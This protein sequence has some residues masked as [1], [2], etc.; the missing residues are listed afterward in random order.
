MWS[1]C[2]GS[3]VVLHSRQKGPPGQ[4]ADALDPG[5]EVVKLCHAEVD[6]VLVLQDVCPSF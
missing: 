4:V 2:G 1:T 5:A 3:V 6:V